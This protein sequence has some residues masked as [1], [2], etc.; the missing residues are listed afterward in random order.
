M[1][2]K[3]KYRQQ[4]ILEELKKSPLL[5]FGEMFSRYLEKFSKTEQTFSKDWK[6]A[7]EQYEAY[8]KKANAEKERISIEL[9]KEAVKQGLKT[10]FD[11]L[12]ILQQQIEQVQKEL[13]LGECEDIK[14]IKG[15]P[16]KIKRPLLPF[17]KSAMRKNIKDLQSEI[18]KIEGDYASDKLDV[19]IEQP[20]FGD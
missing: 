8:Q 10:K 18:S 2:N 4:W 11:R 5:S 12:M 13:E 6:Q 16:K 9:E 17:E 1:T 20:L 15:E 3:P 14:I 7:K 19:F